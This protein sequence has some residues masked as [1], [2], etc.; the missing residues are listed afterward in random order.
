M[1]KDLEHKIRFEAAII[2]MIVAIGVI[3]MVVYLNGLRRGVVS[4]RV[5][6]TRQQAL[7]S[8]TNR[9]VFDMGEAQLSSSLYLST[10]QPRYL[11]DYSGTVERIGVLI[12]TLVVLNP[13]NEPKLLRIELLL[14]QQA[15]KITSLNR[16]FTR[17]NP[18]VVINERLEHYEPQLSPDTLIVSV[19][20]D[21]VVGKAP[22][23]RFFRRLADVFHPR[24]DSVQVIVHE[25][26]DTIRTSSRDSLGII[27]EV[28]DIAR[29]A[30]QDYELNLRTIE[31]QVSA[32][33]VA[34]K[35][36]A[37]EVFALLSELHQETLDATMVTLDANEKTIERNYLYSVIGGSVALVLILIFIGLIITDINK[38]RA[39]RRALESANR[40]IRQIMENRHRLLLSVSHDIKSPL[41]SMLGYLGMMQCDDRVRS[42]QNSSEH[43][44]SM[45]E[46]LL[47]FSSLEQGSLQISRSDFN[48]RDLCREICDMFLPL[49]DQKQLAICFDA[50]D[51]RITLDRVKLKQ[52]VANLVSNAVKYTQSGEIRLQ[53]TFVDGNLRV[54]VRDTGAGIPAAKI[55]LLFR[56]F[57][58]IEENNTLAEGSG[59]GLFVVKG[60]TDLLGGAITVDSTPGEGTRITVCLPA[61]RAARE[62]PHGV[63]RVRVYDDDP[64]M[65]N[66]V[67]G[68]LQQLGHTVVEARPDMI[69]TD[70]EMGETS[71]LDILHKAGGVPVVVMTG[72]ADF[73]TQKAHELG[74][75]GFLA[76]PFTVEAL[77]EMVGEGDVSDDLLGDDR[78]AILSLFRT[79][80]ADNFATLREALAADDFAKA[81]ALCHKM[82]PMFAQLGYPAAELRKVDMHRDNPYAG[83]REDVEK[84]LM[85]RV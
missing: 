45:L 21:T 13:G 30:Q 32:M 17:T 22:R 48:L 67:S 83:W 24:K 56:P 31:Q 79:A 41:N 51:L 36:I 50:D 85:I 19:R 58:R 11:R 62:I 33:I 28:G 55:P 27:S 16:Q 74:F 23:K 20:K 15:Q 44:L 78:E 60:L 5:E 9:L 82:Y 6:I 4:R 77:R 80:T 68:L 57:S 42:M 37:G 3:A 12:D 65:V 2:Y 29:Q 40:Q 35:E 54:E 7:L 53:A 8:A 61:M 10:K 59:L 81:Q 49:A 84:I 73:S 43:I 71:G 25:Q 69:L 18:V 63:K 34:D 39:A 26:T 75:D 38:G 64:V 14:G 76:K 70:M 66:M 1:A 52:I 47:E 46:N 72:R